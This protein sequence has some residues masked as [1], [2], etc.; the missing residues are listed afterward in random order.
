LSSI[1][2]NKLYAMPS[3]QQVESRHTNITGVI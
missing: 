1:A 3:G 2:M